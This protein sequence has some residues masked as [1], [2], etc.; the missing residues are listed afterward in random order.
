[1]SLTVEPCLD[2]A[3]WDALVNAGDGHPLQLWGWGEVKARYDWTAHRYVVREGDTIV[4]SAQ[5]LLRKLPAPFRCLAYIPRGPQAAEPDRARVLAAL[6]AHVQAEHKP[7]A[8]SIEPDWAEPFSPMPKKEAEDLTTAGLNAPPSGWLK[9]IAD[10]GF[11]RSANTGLIPSTLIVDV[12]PDEDALMKGLGSSTRQNV[13]KSF[14]AEN[15]RF[16]EV[17]EQ[18]DLAQILAINRE[19]GRRADFAVHSDDYHYAIRDLMGD[20]SQLLAAWEGDQVVAFVWLVVSGTT[21]FEL[22]GGVNERGM[23]LRLNYGLKF[24]AM[25]HVKAQG[26]E[27]YDF[28]GL[29]NDGISDFKRQFA[30]HE[31]RLIGTWDKPLSPLYPAFAKALPMV[32]RGLKRGV[33]ALKSAASNPKGTMQALREAAHARRSR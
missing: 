13:R 11:A 25:T 3:E 4:G 23:K 8:L 21:A 29:L 20:R 2:P 16:G 17:T 18:G 24:H 28:N 26:V 1:M 30:K 19:T 10:V 12:T 9:E 6:S 15:V 32:R 27:R 22:Y 5:V 7:V 14:R 31:D 33:P